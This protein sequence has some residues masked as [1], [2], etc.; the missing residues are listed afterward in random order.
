MYNRNMLGFRKINVPPCSWIWHPADDSSIIQ[1][2]GTGI[3]V[4]WAKVLGVCFQPQLWDDFIVCFSPFSLDSRNIHGG[5]KGTFT[6]SFRWWERPPLALLKIPSFVP[7]ER[8][9]PAPSNFRGTFGAILINSLCGFNQYSRPPLKTGKEW[10]GEN[11]GAPLLS[12]QGRQGTHMSSTVWLAHAGH[13]PLAP[14]GWASQAF[15]DTV[16][17]VEDIWKWVNLTS[18]SSSAWADLSWK[19]EPPGQARKSCSLQEFHLRNRKD[20]FPEP[21]A[22]WLLW[23]HGHRR[24]C[25]F[26][27]SAAGSKMLHRWI[28]QVLVEW[29]LSIQRRIFTLPAGGN[30]AGELQISNRTGH[31]AKHRMEWDPQNRSNGQK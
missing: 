14:C 4:L 12:F 21:W 22:G 25:R 24:G 2:T 28:Q 16:K 10:G 29:V 15:S 18:I 30:T 11:E 7:A 5:P 9:I 27:F 3:I 6:F 13:S 26:V 8:D 23:E 19:M 20:H 31:R 1:Q 17:S